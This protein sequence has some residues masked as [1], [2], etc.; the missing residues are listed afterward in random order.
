MNTIFVIIQ[1]GLYA[2]GPVAEQSYGT[3]FE[4]RT[5]CEQKLLEITG[6][7]GG[8]IQPSNFEDGFYRLSKTS[9]GE[10]VLF[11]ERCVKLVDDK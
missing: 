1:F 11:V 6:K 8:E 3:F 9:D 2:V 5:A 10:T 4:T 7:L